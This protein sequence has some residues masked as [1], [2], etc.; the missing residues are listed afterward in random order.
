VRRFLSAFALL[1]FLA[2]GLFGEV[3]FDPAELILDTGTLPDHSVCRT[4]RVENRDSRN[5]SVSFLISGEG[6]TV[7]PGELHL[8]P[9]E[10]GSVEV[11]GILT[12]TDKTVPLVMLSDREDVPYL[13]SISPSGAREPESSERPEGD[14]P[15]S[16][17]VFFHTPGCGL[18]EEF[19]REDLPGLSERYGLPLSPEQRNIYEPVHFEY[20]TE[21]LEE[22]GSRAESFPILVAGDRV[23]LGEKGVKEG[24]PA[25]LDSRGKGNAQGEP[26]SPDGDPEKLVLPDL[27]WL[28]VFLAGLLDGINPCAFTTLIFLISYLRLM[29]RKGR[30]ILKIGGSFTAA[31][32][33]TYFLIG[34][35]FFQVIR[36][37]DS[38]FLISRVLRLFMVSLMLVLGVLSLYDYRKIRQGKAEDSLLQLSGESKK[39]IHRTVRKSARSGWMAAGSFGAGALISLYE[40][41]C[42]G[43]IYLP[44][45]VYMVR[46]KASRTALFPLA[47]YNAGFILP[48]VAVFI[49]FYRG[50]D[51]DRFAAFFRKH[52][53]AVKLTTAG[54][55]LTM[56]VVLLLFQ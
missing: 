31:V 54:L 16:P 48:L 38:F 1:A 2:D 22:R 46:Q 19:Y 24:F 49:L 43:Q 32:F 55:F 18:C 39:R 14:G 26:G 53:G 44:M 17:F 4:I 42:T 28:P 51:S 12:D 11:A 10:T 47:L 3:L 8:A 33:L 20:M 7:R 25:Y 9:G 5:L 36:M 56:G 15:F 37:A 50:S 13:Y 34:L 52:M 29:G 27:R 45:V 35:G 41:G 30:D 23:F 21:L 6:W 40:L